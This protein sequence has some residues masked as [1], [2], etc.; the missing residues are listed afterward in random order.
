MK[1]AAACFNLL[2][3]SSCAG[4]RAGCAHAEGLG[5]QVADSESWVLVQ[6]ISSFSISLPMLE[7]AA[8]L[9]SQL[10]LDVL[11]AGPCPYIIERAVFSKQQNLGRCRVQ[12]PVLPQP[13][14]AD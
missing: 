14:W 12:C 5:V 6:W 3:R 4:Y 10:Q 1:L 11:Q 9:W 2:Q 13:A 8:A 7:A